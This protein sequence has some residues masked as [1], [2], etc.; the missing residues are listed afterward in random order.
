M[1]SKLTNMM[2]AAGLLLACHA[3]AQPARDTFATDLTYYM[4]TEWTYTLNKEIPTPKDELGF[5][6]GEQHAEWK[7]VETYMRRLAELSPRI[8]V[9]EYGRT[10][11]RRPFLC[12]T[13]TSEKNQQQ[14]ERIRTE[15]LQLADP[16]VS[17]ALDVKTMPAVVNLMNSVHGNEASSVNASL[18][19]AYFFAAAEDGEI[20]ELLDKVVIN[21]IPGQ[22]PD[23]ISRFA[24]WVNANRSFPDV[25]DPLSRELNEPWPGGRSNHYWHDLNRD[26]LPVQQPEMKYLMKIYHEWMPNTVGDFHEMG[27]NSTYFLEPSDPVCY[28]PAIPEENKT[29]TARVSEYNM[30]ALDRIGS[31]YLSKDLFDSYYLGTGDV[32]GDALGSIAMLFEQAS[33]RGN[34]QK[35]DNGLLTFP[36]TIRNQIVC[37]FGSVKAT[38]ELRETLL[39]Y[40]RRFC[41]DRLKETAALPEKAYVFDGN[42]SEAVSYHFIELLKAH[43]LEVCRLAKDITLGGHT[44]RSDNACIVPVKQRNSMIL[45]SLFESTKHF[46]DSLFYDVSTWN[47]AE[48]F[49]LNC[50]PLTTSLQGLTGAAIA[51]PVFRPGSVK[52]GLTD[53]AYLFDNKE[54]YAPTFVKALQEAGLLVKVSGR[55]ATSDDGAIAY[56]PGMFVLPVAGQKLTARDI[57]DKVVALAAATGVDVQ[58]VSSAKMKDFDLG[59]TDTQTLKE[60]RIA[61]LSGQGFNT[62]ECGSIWY[63]LNGRLKMKPSVIDIA[64]LGRGNL[65]EYNVI[66]IPSGRMISLPAGVGTKLA[67]WVHAGGTLIATGAAYRCIN[68]LKLGELKEKKLT[69]QD[70]SA[71]IPY[72]RRADRSAMYT[73]P[74][75]HLRT[76]I[77]ITHPLAWGYTSPTLPVLKDN[78]LA[79]EKPKEANMAP[80]V[81]DRNPQL[82]GFLRSE[83]S[84][85]LEDTPA[86]ICGRAGNG[87]YIY[88][89]D[90]LT[91]RSYWYGGVR[92]FTNAILFG[93]LI[94]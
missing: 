61:L 56:G 7:Q 70:S 17:G 40:M 86:L 60:P 11:E 83:H 51:A 68:D 77:D 21:L 10:F 5:Q 88:I 22:N 32:Y 8:V 39:D 87:H 46:K 3:G 14:L 65:N 50:A 82:S 45:R 41:A 13:I 93:H 62:G 81:Y 35:T 4:P 9:K 84:R 18:G 71:Y 43:N 47:M 64:A 33:S 73:I 94:R 49:N 66:I 52:G 36:F 80:V 76:R 26:W 24:A 38:Y 25:S 54:Y 79:F 31:L 19:I 15:H 16:A 2:V 85:E 90:D 30:K 1:N 34:V 37:A 58:A 89:A 53:F 12:V 48:A 59:H 57:F 29:L 74:G 42:G 6:L 63:L 28:Y 75:T 20:D 91:F 72:D 23:G 92:M 27:S 69:R 55:G 44:Y 67:E 78:M